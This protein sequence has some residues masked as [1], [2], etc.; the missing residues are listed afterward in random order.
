MDSTWS[1]KTEPSSAKS[2]ANQLDCPWPL[3]FYQGIL[4]GNNV[5]YVQPSH[6]IVHK[7]TIHA[8]SGS[9][10]LVFLCSILLSFPAALKALLVFMPRMMLVFSSLIWL[11]HSHFKFK[12]SFSL[13]LWESLPL[14][15]SACLSLQ[16]P[17]AETLNQPDCRWA[18]IWEHSAGLEEHARVFYFY[19]ASQC[20][21]LPW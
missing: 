12:W 15:L 9:G 18:V 14:Y 7:Q 8:W 2:K 11:Q 6:I 21:S 5:F 17:D 20:S 10:C 13:K 4:S 16:S 1:W 3:Y 19:Q